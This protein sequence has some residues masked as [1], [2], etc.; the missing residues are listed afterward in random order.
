MAK[1]KTAKALHKTAAASEKNSGTQPVP[2]FLQRIAAS[3][4]SKAAL[5]Q[6]Y[7]LP[8]EALLVVFIM[9]AGIF[10]RLEDLQMW[11]KYESRAFHEGRPLHTTFDAYFYLSLAKDIVDGTYN[12]VDEKRGVPDCPPRPMPPPLISVMAAAIAKITPWHLSW[13]GAVLPAVLGALFALPLCFFGRL[14]GGPL[15]GFTAALLGLL[16]PF[17]VYRSNLGRFDTDC[18]NVTFTLGAACLFLKFAEICALKRYLYFASA[19]VLYVFFIWWWDQTPAVVTAI[20]FLPFLVALALY[21][22]PPRKEALIFAS[23]IAAGGLIFILLKGPLPFFHMVKSIFLQYLYISKDTSGDFP[24][25]GVTISEQARPSLESI[26]AYTTL[27][28]FS[29][30]LAVAGI[31]LMLWKRFRQTLFLGSLIILAVLAFT[32]AN[33]FLIF[34]IPLLAL[35]AG[36]T[37]S[38]LWSLRQRFIPLYII[39]PILL[40][41]MLVPL[42]TENSQSVQWP[43][44]SPSIVA[45]MDVALHKT[46]SDAVIWAWWDHGYALTYFARRATVNDGSIHSGERTVYTAIPYATD[47]FRYAANFMHFYVK[48]GMPGISM[49][50]TAAGSRSAGLQL[51]KNVL[52]AGPEAGRDIIEQAQL[53]PSEKLATTGDWLAFFFP[54][55]RRPVYLFVDS[56]LPKITYWWYWFGTWDVTKRDGDHPFY[57]SSSPVRI[58][59]NRITGANGLNLNMD[60]GELLFNDKRTAVAA[61]AIRDLNNLR[62]KNFYNGS[63]YRFEMFEQGRFGAMMENSIAESVFNKLYIRHTPDRHYF[64]PVELSTPAYQLWEVTGDSLP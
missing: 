4:E 13:I 37:L 21:Y 42:I 60:T 17:Y 54:P 33:R 22:R 44:E 61:V 29:F 55:E 12:A 6:R 56:L 49:L 62:E 45:G 43:K 32:Y 8:I 16:Y 38:F 63:R 7:H 34:F 46:P 15:C 57:T 10:V 39:V 11:R 14:L 59:D 19:I 1:K 30:A 18:L 5:L 25:I 52:S 64:K 28:A 26:I 41:F 9:I 40:V 24:N 35:G 50:C 20:T 3:A 48:R 31:G 36:Y 23:V 27:N 2:G 58:K 47:S 51:M 53:K